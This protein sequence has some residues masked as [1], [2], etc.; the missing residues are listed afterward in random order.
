M[1]SSIITKLWLIGITVGSFSVLT[2]NA[3]F[4]HGGR[5]VG[6]YEINVGFMDEPA[7]E[8]RLNGVDLRI[9]MAETGAPVEGLDQ[10][11]Q[12]EV[13]HISSG[14]SKTLDLQP[15]AAEPGRYTAAL[16]PTAPGEFRF[17]FLGTIG[18][19]TIDEVFESGPDHF[20][21]I[22]SSAA[23]QIPHQLPEMREVG[24][25][26]RGTM[27]SATQA[28]DSAATATGLAVAG[29]VLGAIGA[30]A[31]VSSLVMTRK[32]IVTQ[33]AQSEL[34]MAEKPSPVS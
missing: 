27:D 4:A 23:L 11:L 28:Q 34:A 14:G 29:L 20:A 19:M 7:Y 1:K 15:V 6:Q 16:I 24:A 13:T 33:P 26:V 17:R 18:E 25:A 21:A 8:G 9:E 10:T 3:A 2:V 5:E 22:E 32:R 31:G 30:V 12:V